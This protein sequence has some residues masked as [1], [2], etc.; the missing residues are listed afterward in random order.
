MMPGEWSDK[1]PDAAEAASGIC[2]LLARE[3][4]RV[5]PRGVQTW[6]SAA[7]ELGA[8]V[9]VEFLLA[10]VR[11]ESDPS[12]ETALRLHTAFD[13]VIDT[14]EKVAQRYDV[15]LQETPQ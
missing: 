11:W 12:E 14:W 1:D 4:A 8:S 15:R 9:E 10:L 13:V 3:V 5:A 2:D 6:G 7:F